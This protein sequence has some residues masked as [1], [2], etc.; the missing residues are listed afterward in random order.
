VRQLRLD[1]IRIDGGTQPRS[2]IQR[3]VVDDYV[4]V[5][6]VLPPVVVFYD[7]TTYWLADGFH[8]W[9]A[10]R[11][12]GR[13][14][15][16]VELLQG[17][18]RDAILFSVG[19]N[20]EH[21]LRRTNSDK[22]RAVETLLADAEW[23][24]WSDN[25]LARRC[26][27]SPHLVADARKSRSL[28]IKTHSDCERAYVTKHGTR[29]KMKTRNI[30]VAKRNRG[31]ARTPEVATVENG[32]PVTPKPA[33][34]PAP[35][36]TAALGPEPA[37]PRASELA[38]ISLDVIL[39]RLTAKSERG[40]DCDTVAGVV[41]AAASTLLSGRSQDSPSLQRATARRLV[42]AMLPELV[43]HPELTIFK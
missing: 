22:R 15:I 40:L 29:A 2:E 41:Y 36:D 16:K 31:R 23:V 30:G 39:S 35:A 1:Q 42:M 14:V 33:V 25:E 32:R 17:T 27:V 3:D 8:R 26:V 38:R 18:R 6:D 7:G 13:D 21:G 10:H 34:A 19:A 9:H 37:D 28:T 43:A 4:V 24:R 12:A 5:I 11:R 20:V